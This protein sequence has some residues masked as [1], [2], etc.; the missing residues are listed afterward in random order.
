MFFSQ[1][2][3]APGP[4]WVRKHLLKTGSRH[5]SLKLFSPSWLTEELFSLSLEIFSCAFSF[6]SF[7]WAFISSS[8]S[9]LK[10]M[11]HSLYISLISVLG[12]S[13]EHSIFSL[14]L[15]TL[16][17][18]SVSQCLRP[19]L[20]LLVED[21]RELG[22]YRQGFYFLPIP[23]KKTAEWDQS[24]ILYHECRSQDGTI[25]RRKMKISVLLEMSISSIAE[26]QGSNPSL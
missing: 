16:S 11:I 10:W 25:L 13:R 4:Q 24:E 21:Q 26:W 20:H 1:P 9:I 2:Q 23:T 17:L 7:P 18:G 22:F 5:A 14:M 15:R 12:K 3:L 6:P 8:K 19:S